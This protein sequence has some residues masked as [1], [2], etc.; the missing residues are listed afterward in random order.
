[1]RNSMRQNLKCTRIAF[2]WDELSRH[3]ID[4]EIALEF[5]EY[6]FCVNRSWILK[7][8]KGYVHYKVIDLPHPEIETGTIDAFVQKLFRSAQR[9]RNNIRK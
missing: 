1:M 6:Q 5:M 8:I 3:G 7:I 4:S 2:Y 9:E